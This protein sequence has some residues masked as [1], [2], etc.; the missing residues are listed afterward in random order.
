M[1]TV[2]PGASTLLTGE[3]KCLLE[4]VGE[5]KKIENWGEYFFGGK[6]PINA[7]HRIRQFCVQQLQFLSARFARRLELYLEFFTFKN[8]FKIGKGRA[9]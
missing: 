4:T 1:T 9:E 2:G 5:S 7:W 8:V 6:L 3:D